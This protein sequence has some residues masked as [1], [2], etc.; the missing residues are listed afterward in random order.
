[1]NFSNSGSQNFGHDLSFKT[2]N[3]LYCELKFTTINDQLEFFDEQLWISDILG[4]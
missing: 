3:E 4:N 2:G 1:M